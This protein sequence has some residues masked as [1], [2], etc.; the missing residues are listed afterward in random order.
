MPAQ[1]TDKNALERFLSLFSDVRSK[2][3]VTTLLLTLNIFLLL[4]AHYLNK[5][6][7][8]PLILGM[9]GGAELK[10]YTT[11]GQAILLL[12]IVPAYG[13]LASRVTRIRLI[14]IVTAIFVAFLVGFYVLGQAG[15]PIGIPFYLYQGIFS[16]MVIAQFW[17]YANDLFSTEEG[18]RL[19]P[20]V[21]FGGTAGAVAGSFLAKVLVEPLGVLQLLL[22]GAGILVL[23][24]VIAHVINVRERDRRHAEREEGDEA[25]EAALSKEGGFQLLWRNKYLGAIAMLVLV[26]TLVNT[27]GEYIV[28]RLAEN[29]AKAAVAAVHNPGGEALTDAQLEEHGSEIGAHI[30]EFFGG[31]Y[32]YV[33]ILTAFLQLFVVSRVLKYAGVRWALMV[34]P[35]I[36]LGSSGLIAVMPVLAVVKWAKIVENS[37]DYSLQNTTRQALFLPTS[38][39]AKYKAKAAIDT[40]FVRLADILSAGVVAAGTALAIGIRGFAIANLVLLAGVVLLALLIGR[41]YKRAAADKEAEE[42]LTA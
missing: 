41:H 18:E 2:E 42:A 1:S 32:L 5:V 21:A 4:T 37:V 6:V 12:F 23:F 25:R 27:N 31:F 40:F 14:T 38:R 19:F 39:E 24:A 15:A 36:A 16:V 20:I 7:R 33:N 29:N 13:W 34:L 3:G 17:S 28:S 30:G 22:V 11:G 9:E 10:S 8:E 35:V 26:Y